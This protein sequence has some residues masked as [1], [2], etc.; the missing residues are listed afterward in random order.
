MKTISLILLIALSLI[1]ISANAG[2]SSERYKLVQLGS[3]RADQYLLDTQT[4]AIWRGVCAPGG[5]SVSCST[6]WQRQLVEGQNI[7]TK[8]LQQALEARQKEASAAQSQ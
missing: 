7:S 8:V 1:S 5:D 3:A 2:G 6:I 4:G